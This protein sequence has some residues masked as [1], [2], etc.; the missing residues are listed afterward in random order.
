MI[1]KLFLAVYILFSNINLLKAQDEN[2]IISYSID[3]LDTLK[4]PK[5][6]IVSYLKITDYAIN[7]YEQS[8]NK[9]SSFKGELL[10]SLLSDHLKNE[11][12]NGNLIPCSDDRVKQIILIYQKYKYYIYQPKVSNFLKFALKACMGDWKYIYSRISELWFFFPSLFLFLTLLIFSILNLFG[13]INWRF[14]SIYT[15][16]FLATILIVIFC[17]ILFLNTCEIYVTN[18]SFYGICI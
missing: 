3:Q 4:F 18:H 9:D 13:F 8:G 11:I 5:M 12:D 10:M 17:S 15:W 2:M 14:R 6:S 16:I 1:K 7:L